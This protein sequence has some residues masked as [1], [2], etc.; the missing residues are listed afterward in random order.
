MSN[1]LSIP[2]SVVDADWMV[3]AFYPK[4]AQSLAE[5]AEGGVLWIGTDSSREGNY[6]LQ[7]IRL[8]ASEYGLPCEAL[9]VSEHDPYL[10]WDD[11]AGSGDE[12]AKLWQLAPKTIA[13][14]EN[15]YII[16]SRFVRERRSV[17]NAHA[18]LHQIILVIPV[19]QFLRSELKGE[20][21]VAVP[22]FDEHSVERRQELAVALLTDAFPNEDIEQRQSRARALIDARPAS[23]AEL[24]TWVD[25]F[26]TD[27][28]ATL[29]WR[30]PPPVARQ[31]H[32]P[33]DVP[34]RL[35]LQTQL[36]KAMATFREASAAFLAWRG[37]P[38]VNP[39]REPPDPFDARDPR[40]WFSGTISYLACYVFDAVDDCFT[41]LLGC[42]WNEAT[43]EIE[44]TEPVAFHGILRALR[45]VM[46]HGLDQQHP[47]NRETL[48]NVERWCH[49]VLGSAALRR[50][51]CRALT[52]RLLREWEDAAIRLN[53]VVQHAPQSNNRRLL[54]AQLDIEQRRLPKY[55]WR[56]LLVEV[57]APLDADLDFDRILEKYLT[58]LQRDLQNTPEKG[59]ALVSRARQFVSDI[60]A[61]EL[62]RCPI[63]GEDLIAA[64]F[65][66][67]PILGRAK[68]FVDKQWKSD[69]KLTKEQLL[70]LALDQFKHELSGSTS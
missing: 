26:A 41:K 55:R 8:F 24:E 64:G 36:T 43:L 48:R 61:V 15:G 53:T 9:T 17:L 60:V 3:S 63:S 38:L 18:R 14:I 46:Q 34:T 22:T 32:I 33:P 20:C 58:T 47:R 39:I 59:E 44:A 66:Q 5:N 10:L 35:E 29:L 12:P 50:D 28:S 13:C 57:C 6:L 19:A 45:T 25:Y 2:V 21:F 16:P 51:H 37:E 4:I 40:Y 54:E 42:R 1:L 11:I 65:K 69:S 23:R 67:G 68:A 62:A 27:A 70:V 56:E 30:I 52:S 31:A 49:A 7:R